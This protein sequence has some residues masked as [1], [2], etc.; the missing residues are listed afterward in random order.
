MAG[1]ALLAI[2]PQRNLQGYADA[3]FDAGRRRADDMNTARVGGNLW[4]K[5][6]C[7]RDADEVGWPAASSQLPEDPR[8]ADMRDAAALHGGV[9]PLASAVATAWLPFF[10]LSRL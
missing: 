4:R 7:L 3:F 2:L 1:P 9:C 5:I 8:H 6:P 10:F